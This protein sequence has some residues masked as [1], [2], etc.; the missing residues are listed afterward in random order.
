MTIRPAR[1]GDP[2]FAVPLIQDTTGHIGLILTGAAPDA[3]APNAEPQDVMLGFFARA[4]HRLSVQN[5]WIA[6]RSG[7]RLGPLLGDV[8][9][10]CKALDGPFRGHLRG[11]GLPGEWSV[12]TLAVTAAARGQGIGARLLRE[13]AAQAVSRGLGRVGLLLEKGYRAAR[14]CARAGF[15]AAGERMVGGHPYSHIIRL[16]RE[17]PQ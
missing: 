9:A 4:G 7:E 11:R 17:T 13:A 16:I 15:A 12:D 10:D 5:V 8:G 1:P 6:E 2:P 3:E 14:L